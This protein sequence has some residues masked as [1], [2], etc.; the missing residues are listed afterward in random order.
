MIT[1]KDLEI[2]NISYTNKDFG[3]IYPEL[4]ELVKKLTNKWDPEATNESDPGIVLLKLIAFLGDKLNYNIDKNTLEQ[5]IVSATQESSMRR[6]TEMLGYNMKYYRSATTK[7]GFRYLGALNKEGADASSI[8]AQRQFYIK[9]FDTTFKTDDDIVY[10]LLED[11]YITSSEKQST[12]KLA[13]QGE[14]HALS[15]LGGNNSTD[16]TLIQ[17]YNLDAQNRVYFPVAEVAEN[18]IFINKEVYD[19]TYHKE[20][21]HRVDSLND[22]ELGEKVFK[23]GYDSSS[24]RPYIEFPSDIASLIEDGLEIWYIV[25][26]GEN[27]KV[28]NNKLTTFN[29]IKIMDGNTADANVISAPLNAEDYILTNSSSTEGANPESLTEAYNNFKKVI[30]TFDTLVSC[31][32]YSNYINRYE[33]DQANKLVSN[34]IATDYRTDP[35]YSKVI[36]TRDETGSSY[37]NFPVSKNHSSNSSDLILHG[38]NAVNQIIQTQNLYEKTY[39]GLSDLSVQ[40]IALKL[41]DVKTINHKLVKPALNSINYVEAAYTLKAN[42]STKYKVNS[43][44]QK[45]IIKNIKNSLYN[46]FNASKVDFG[47]EIPFETLVN[48]IQ[49]ADTRIKNVSLNEP[50]VDFYLNKSVE[51]GNERIKYNP[52]THIAL[53]V[54]NILAG[55]LPLYGEDTSFEYDYSMDFSSL[56]KRT[57]LCAIDASFDVKSVIVAQKLKKNETVQLI[58]DS[59]NTEIIYPAYVYYAFIQRGTEAGQKCISANTV[60]KLGAN[61]TLYL[62]YTDSSN[63]AQF[64]TY[65]EGAI[66]RPNFNIFNTAGIARLTSSDAGESKTASKFALWADKKFDTSVNANNWE[67]ADKKDDLTPLFGIGADEQIELIKRNEVTLDA[68]SN[69]FWY[70]KPRITY[71]ND[72]SAEIQNEHGDLLFPYK[73]AETGKYYYILEEGEMFI[74]P[75]KDMTSLNILESGTKLEYSEPSIRRAGDDIIDFNEL[76]NGVEDADVGTFRKSFNWQIIEKPIT[77]VESVISSYAEG[78]SILASSAFGK[79]WTSITSLKVNGENVLIDNTTHPLIRTVLSIT[80][81][82]ANPQTCYADQTIKYITSDVEKEETGKLATLTVTSIPENTLF[83]ITPSVD[84]YNDLCVLQTISYT[85]DEGVLTPDTYNNRYLHTFTSYQLITY[86]ENTGGIPAEITDKSVEMNKFVYT[87]QQKNLK[88]LNS[89]DE[90]VIP[91]ATLKE[92]LYDEKA[93]DWKITKLTVPCTDTNIKVGVFDSYSNKSILLSPEKGKITIDL[94]SFENNAKESDTIYI[95]K[96]KALLL[97]TYLDEIK[98]SIENAVKD[99][100]SDGVFDWTGPRNN[101]KIINSYEPL[102]SFFDANNI[103]NKFTLPKIDFDHSEFN[104]TGSSK[105]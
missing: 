54:D 33:D 27:G 47:E 19:P 46:N 85:D 71:K 104:I 6:L 87:L 91:F 95:S 38:T 43:V 63:K 21:W 53:I 4:L 103:Y 22:Q 65:T 86:T 81:S 98:D 26:S 100:D 14:L 77:I 24:N 102:Y 37:K 62:Q 16:S 3:Q 78:D 50:E 15:L 68:Y 99:A 80:S 36:F 42:I 61:D 97:Y 44:E 49:N 51:T 2:E 57:K 74:Y 60:Y 79:K 39:S 9:A 89:R 45:E 1:N 67:N 52:S 70:I 72:G 28:L 18:G 34:V 48:V 92:C 69:A 12:E 31:K 82:S 11:M 29:S 101:S 76:V 7:I 73:D 55:A 25:S 8:A 93:K 41:D 30:G 96:P 13:I 56:Q 10:T 23:F 5:F 20:A 17:L 88:A 32:D 105:I 59:Y 35:A 66:I 75:N 58:S 64:I 40:E 83:Q 94:T 84:T 90:Y